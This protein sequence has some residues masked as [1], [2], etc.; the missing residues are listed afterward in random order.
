[1]VV[2]MVGEWYSV[3]AMCSCLASSLTSVGGV[4]VGRGRVRVGW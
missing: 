3:M 1:M 4:F 2:V